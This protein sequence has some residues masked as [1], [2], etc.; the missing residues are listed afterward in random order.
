MSFE[1]R[2]DCDG[3]RA[4][5]SSLPRT[6]LQHERNVIPM[7]TM[8]TPLCNKSPDPI[9]ESNIIATCRQ[10]SGFINPFVAT[11]D[12]VWICRYCGFSNR[13]VADDG[14]NLPLGLSYSTVEYS[15]GKF[16]SLPP[17]FLYVVDTC[18]ESEDYDAYD[19][20]RDSLSTSLS[21]LPENAL[22]G[23]VS[24]G[25]HVSIHNLSTPQVSYSFNGAKEHNLEEVRKSLGLIDSTLKTSSGELFGS[26]GKNFLQPVGLAEYQIGSIIDSLITNTFPRVSGRERPLRATGAAINIASLLLTALLTPYGTNGGNIMCF[27]GGACTYGP[28]KIVD[29]QL[30]EPLRSHHDIETAKQSTLTKNIKL[31]QQS[32]NFQVNYSLVLKAKEFYKSIT[33]KL[34]KLGISC[35]YFVG[36]YDQI[37]LYEMDEVCRKTGGV[38][39]MSDS[40]STS[41]FKQ[42]FM[43]FLNKNDDSGY[44]DFGL[45]ATLEVKVER[46]LKIQGLIGN[47]IGLPVKQQNNQLISKIVKGQGNTNCWKLCHINPQS[48]FAI[49]FE[50]L[51]SSFASNSTIIQYI[52]HYQHPSGEFKLRVTTVPINIIHD[53]DFP[54]LENDFDQE[55]AVV[56]IVRDSVNHLETENVVP[57]DVIKTIDKITID[58]CS[59][60]AHYN[61][62]VLT[63]FMLS[64]KFAFLP[65]FI[66]H[67][68]RSPFITVFNNS[69]DETSFLRHILMHEDTNNSLIMIQ[70]TLLSYDID[71]YGAVD[72]TTGQEMTDPEAVL[73]DSVSLGKS[74]ILLLDTFFQ[75]LIFHGDQVAQWRKAGYHEME[76]YDHFKSFLEAPKK[77]ALD[78]LM[79]R[80]PLPRFID[81]DEGGSQARFLMAKLNPSSSYSTNPNQFYGNQMDVLTDDISL[82]LFMDHIQRIV[83]AK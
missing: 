75:I 76:G 14:G 66:Y 37:G 4:T 59:R 42:S 70:P 79:D 83:T 17:L 16:N 50:K 56:S 18:F 72:E 78:I 22:V 35:S 40:F 52:T 1:A 61:K 65:Q 5:W 62:G 34:V 68:R 71:Q 69:P 55:M 48:S 11:T 82:Q 7:S 60:F 9:P 47:A 23:F 46:D 51:D 63:S 24:F 39:I 74:K 21:L 43:K 29:N 3:I 38:I 13:L 41:I 19:S 28:G 73:L 25:K 8:Y 10:C 30:K 81:C 36:S 77:E 44:L 49:Y 2:E 67:L 6:K 53:N 27:V 20:L 64:R 33:Q 26:I 32:N 15:T 12:Q 57:T 31:P 54:Q 45:N 58:F 80:F